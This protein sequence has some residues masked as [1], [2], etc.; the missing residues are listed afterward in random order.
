MN[1]KGWKDRWSA[2]P[3]MVRAE[4]KVP[5][6]GTI[7]PSTVAEKGRRRAPAA[8][9]RGG[10]RGSQVGMS[11]PRA[12]PGTATALGGAPYGRGELVTR[13]YAAAA[14]SAMPWRVSSRRLPSEWRRWGCWWSLPA[15]GERPPT[16][17]VYGG[18]THTASRPRGLDDGP[19]PARASKC[20]G[21]LCGRVC[22]EG[23]CTRLGGTAL[24]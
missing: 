24:A 14:K 22:P 1:S 2:P 11:S 8:T 3:T 4:G 5:V 23:G 13:A 10:S 9:E 7:D 6:A 20:A 16:S 12:I 17:L 18:R 15:V 19:G 21:G